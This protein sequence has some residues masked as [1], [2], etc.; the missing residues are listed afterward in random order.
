VISFLGDLEW[1]SPDFQSYMTPMLQLLSDGQAR[2]ITDISADLSQHFQLTSIDLQ[3][4]IPS[5]KKSRHYD[6]VGWS[7][8]YMKQA[9]LLGSPKRGWYQI[10]ERGYQA[11]SS[12]SIVNSGSTGA[13]QG[14]L[15]TIL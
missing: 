8:T 15:T 14:K 1:L 13:Y 5:G 12:G 3:D 9:G 4:L 2:R 7:A 11:L 6:R 10:T